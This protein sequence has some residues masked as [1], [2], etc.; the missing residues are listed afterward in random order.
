M[1]RRLKQH[2]RGRGGVCECSQSGHGH[3]RRCSNGLV[4]E[5]RWRPW[6]KNL[7][8]TYDLQN[9]EIQ[10]EKCVRTYADDDFFV[11]EREIEQARKNIRERQKLEGRLEQQKREER[12]RAEERRRRIRDYGD[13][14]LS[15]TI[16]FWKG[17]SHSGPTNHSL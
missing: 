8:G 3:G 12:E 10:C 13:L 6:K 14:E 11:P 2:G 15:P 16:V 5:S 4:L 17:K 9:C 1:K 7:S